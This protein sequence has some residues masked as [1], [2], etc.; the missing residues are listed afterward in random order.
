VNLGGSGELPGLAGLHIQPCVSLS[1]TACLSGE[2]PDTFSRILVLRLRRLLA[3]IPS[4]GREK[5]KFR[6]EGAASD[7]PRS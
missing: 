3:A 4:F 2:T 5:A 1:V 7:L 6:E